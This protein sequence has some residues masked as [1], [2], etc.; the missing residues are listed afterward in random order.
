[1]GKPILDQIKESKEGKAMLEDLLN[2]MIMFA[3]ADEPPQMFAQNILSMISTQPG[4][5][6]VWN[7]LYILPFEKIWEGVFTADS[8]EGKALASE[9]VVKFWKMVK[10]FIKKKYLEM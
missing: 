6:V 3:Q 9:K 1:M 5:A 2:Q 8:N 10:E 4:F 7:H